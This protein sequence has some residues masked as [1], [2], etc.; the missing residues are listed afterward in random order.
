[1]EFL[2]SNHHWSPISC[3]RKLQPCS[4][5]LPIFL[6]AAPPAVPYLRMSPNRI[7]PD[8]ANPAPIGHA[9][10]TDAEL[11]SAERSTASR[12]KLWIQVALRAQTRRRSPDAVDRRNLW[13]SSS[14]LAGQEE[15]AS[16]GRRRKCC[17]SRREA[18]AR[19]RA[20]ASLLKVR[21]RARHLRR[22][23]RR[24]WRPSGR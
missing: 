15:R 2:S 11:P 5:P 8:P 17:A 19:W 10:A 14:L 1:M 6:E 21:G 22:L 7:R 20:D 24:K 18:C 13:T 4:R 23:Q 9:E 12:A 3:G 16:Q